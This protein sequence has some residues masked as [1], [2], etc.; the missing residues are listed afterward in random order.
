[1][2]NIA[3]YLSVF[4]LSLIY[5]FIF[6][7][8]RFFRYILFFFVC[9]ASSII[10][11]F[12]HFYA[13][14]RTSLISNSLEVIFSK[15]CVISLIISSILYLT[16]YNNEGIYIPIVFERYIL[17]GYFS[18][19]LIILRIYYLIDFIVLWSWNVDSRKESILDF[20]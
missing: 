11:Y 6:F 13:I 20:R 12:L 3:V 4:I 17:V 2:W 10:I 16:S 18:L 8:K 14:W 15:F 7:S 9:I 5:L 1:M 19:R